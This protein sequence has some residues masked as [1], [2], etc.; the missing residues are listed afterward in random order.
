M[1]NQPEFKKRV[2]FDWRD[3]R[4]LP[5]LF[6][7]S[8]IQSIFGLHKEHIF[9]NFRHKTIIY[10]IFEIT[11]IQSIPSK[12]LLDERQTHKATH[13]GLRDSRHLPHFSKTLVHGFF[14]H[15]TKNSILS[16]FCLKRE[17]FGNFSE[18][19]VMV[20]KPSKDFVLASEIL[21]I[22]LIHWE[23]LFFLVFCSHLAS[24]K[25]KIRRYE[26]FEC[27]YFRF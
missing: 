3:S 5:Y 16:F 14:L 19:K 9:F 13:F 7:S 27:G 6:K 15:F 22:Y 1:L 8:G 10:R 17:E 25:A 18:F 11:I 26:L 21:Y 23:M 20:K 2:Y 4:H 24:K 12:A